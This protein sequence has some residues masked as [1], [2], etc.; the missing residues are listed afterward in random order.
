MVSGRRCLEITY[1]VNPLV[2]NTMHHKDVDR[3]DVIL[4][5]KVS[6]DIRIYV[7]APLAAV[8]FKLDSMYSLTMCLSDVCSFSQ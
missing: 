7:S 5:V 3:K 2:S 8:I 1:F 4:M 6:Y